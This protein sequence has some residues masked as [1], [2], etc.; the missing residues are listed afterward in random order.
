M[1]RLDAAGIDGAWI[2]TDAHRAG[3]GVDQAVAAATARN[4]APRVPATAAPGTVV[5]ALGTVV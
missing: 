3:A 1:G 5:R 4:P 2:L